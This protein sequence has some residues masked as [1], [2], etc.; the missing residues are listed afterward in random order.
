MPTAQAA[1][2]QGPCAGKDPLTWQRAHAV[3]L[4]LRRKSH[5]AVDAYRCPYCGTYHV[6]RRPQPR[7]PR[8]T[9]NVRWRGGEWRE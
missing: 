6:G 2:A 3:A 8:L 9:P 5:E 1:L 7:P 4:E